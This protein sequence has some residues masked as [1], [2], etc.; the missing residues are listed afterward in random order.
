MRDVSQLLSSF[1]Q[2]LMTVEVLSTSPDWLQPDRNL[3]HSDAALGLCSIHNM[4]P[5]WMDEA[6]NAC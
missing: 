3:A 6:N 1:G 2:V 5:T 4:I